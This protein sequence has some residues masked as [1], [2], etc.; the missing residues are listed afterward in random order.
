MRKWPILLALVLLSAAACARAE[1][2]YYTNN[3]DIYYHADPDCDRP[4]EPGRYG[5]EGMYFYEREC[6]Q[7]VEI[8]E[9][10]AVAFDR[11]ACPVCVKD[12]EVAYLGDYPPDW[13]GEGEPWELAGGQLNVESTQYGRECAQTYE[14]FQ[15]HYEEIYNRGMDA[16]ERRH[17]YPDAFAGVW[18]N[19]SGG[20][21]YA[22][23]NPTREITDAFK[24]MFGGGAWIVPAKYGYNEMRAMQDEVFDRIRAWEAAHPEFDIH[25]NMASVDERYNYLGVGLYGADWD[26]AMPALDAELELPVWVYFFRSSELS[27]AAEAP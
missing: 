9:E 2:I 4:G 26:E 6:F 18:F 25:V 15:A 19:C 3:E 24:N 17:P 27:W 5:I 20:Y 8:S 10:A 12:W 13:Q 11:A 21:S 1:E 22:V 14:R 23:V 7:K 16:F